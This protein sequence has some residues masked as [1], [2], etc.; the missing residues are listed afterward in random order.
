M[1]RKAPPTPALPAFLWTTPMAASGVDPTSGGRWAVTIA[2][3]G[4]RF[5]LTVRFH[6][7]SSEATMH[8][9]LNDA[10]QAGQWRIER[11]GYCAKSDPL[12]L[13]E[14]LVKPAAPQ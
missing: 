12:L 8:D 9:D 7:G 5:A 4:A 13:Q 6:D 2:P 3:A 11:A 1:P 14:L 10:Q